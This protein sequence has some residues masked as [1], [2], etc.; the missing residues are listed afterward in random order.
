MVNNVWVMV[1]DSYN[2]DI[3]SWIV[4]VLCVIAHCCHS[5]NL[6]DCDLQCFVCRWFA[7]LPTLL[8]SLSFSQRT[9]VK[10]VPTSHLHD[11]TSISTWQI[12]LGSTNNVFDVTQLQKWLSDYIFQ[13]IC[14]PSNLLQTQSYN[15]QMQSALCD[16]LLELVLVRRPSAHR[17]QTNV[18]LCTLRKL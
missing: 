3:H 9:V 2:N 5:V 6:L 15:M 16:W 14:C 18:T 13:P 12:K 4:H 10:S 8:L 11:W 17:V 7:W 1:Y